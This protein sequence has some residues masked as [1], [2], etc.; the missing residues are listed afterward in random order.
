MG[1]RGRGGNNRAQ[2]QAAQRAAQQRAAQQAAL[3]A[4]Q[5][6]AAAQARAI[7]E[8]QQRAAAEQS[9]RQAEAQRV[10]QVN[11]ENVAGY[12]QMQQSFQTATQGVLPRLEQASMS[13]D[14]ARQQNQAATY[15]SQGGAATGGGADLGAIRQQ[16]LANIGVA[17]PIGAGVAGA[18]S[19]N[20][21]PPEGAPSGAPQNMGAMIA[22]NMMGGGGNAPTNRFR[23]PNASKLSFGGS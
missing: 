19:T 20:N 12:D 5:A 10:A 17:A 21:N 8:A 23:L 9:A 22:A 15:Q 7:A 6:A 2:Q 13:E 3:Q 18:A 4:Q 14:T 11:A 1:G 16:A